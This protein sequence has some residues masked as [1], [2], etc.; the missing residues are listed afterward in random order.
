MKEV[1]GS[2][3]N[4]VLSNSEQRG[5]NISEQPQEAFAINTQTIHVV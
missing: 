2:L 4:L 3:T 1:T 5:V